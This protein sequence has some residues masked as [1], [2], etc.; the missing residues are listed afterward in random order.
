MQNP[1]IVF[2]HIKKTIAIVQPGVG[3]RKL[4]NLAATQRKQVASSGR[5]SR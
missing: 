3:D 4:A 1:T 5:P 2:D